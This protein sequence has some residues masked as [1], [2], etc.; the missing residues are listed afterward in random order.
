ML[1]GSLKDPPHRSL[2]PRQHLTLKFAPSAL[3]AVGAG[4][5]V[6]CILLLSVL[7]RQSGFQQMFSPPAKPTSFNSEVLLEPVRVAAPRGSLLGRALNQLL[8]LCTQTNK[9]QVLHGSPKQKQLQGVSLLPC[10]CSVPHLLP[11]APR[12][13]AERLRASIID[14]S[15]H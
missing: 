13:G 8:Q 1:C 4:R 10:L 7:A 9:V 6:T 11:L 15:Q 3:L 12:D 5:S 14:E 2:P